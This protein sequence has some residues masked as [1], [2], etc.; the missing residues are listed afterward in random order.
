MKVKSALHLPCLFYIVVPDTVIFFGVDGDSNF[1][2]ED[3]DDSSS[4]T[5]TFF[6]FAVA[7]EQPFAVD[8]FECQLDTG[9]IARC[10]SGSITYTGLSPGT[11]TFSVNYIIEPEEGQPIRDPTPA[12]RIWDIIPDVIPPDDDDVVIPPDDDDVV[13]PPDDDDDDV[14]PPDD[15]AADDDAADDDAADDD[16]ADDDA[17]D[18][19]AADDDAADDDAADDDA[20]DDDA[21][22]DDAA[23]DDAADDDAADD[24]AADDDA[25]DDDAA[26]DDDNQPSNNNNQPSK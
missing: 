2:L 25:A 5:I 12:I 14:I 21:A 17:A 24:D 8:G 16:A 9:A 11:H 20:A 19:D 26:D 4:G 15:D 6:F 3:F 10:D 1:I 7:N 18:D 22:D 13:I 23:D